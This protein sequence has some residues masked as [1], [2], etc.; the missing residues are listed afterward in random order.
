[1]QA[2]CRSSAGAVAL[3]AI[4]LIGAALGAA[5]AAD[6]PVK[7][8]AA[9][10]LPPWQ[11]TLDEDTRL[12]SWSGSRGFPAPGGAVVPRGSGAQ[13]YA[14][15]SLGVVGQ[16]A[17][18]HK[19]EF[20]IR[21]GVV[22][23]QQTTANQ[24]G[25]FS[26]LTD[27][28]ATGTYTYLGINGI[29]PYVSLALNLPTGRSALLGSDSNGRLDPDLVGIGVSGEGFNVGPTVG[30]NIPVGDSLM[31]GLAVGYTNRGSYKKDSLVNPATFTPFLGPT[32]TFDP[33]D[34]VTVT[35]TAAYVQGPL[36]WRT[37]ANGTF[38]SNTN[39]TGTLNGLPFNGAL[40]RAGDRYTVQSTAS[41]DWTKT[42]TSVLAAIYTH[43]NKNQVL[44]AN[45]PPLVTEMFNSNNDVIQ[46]TLDNKFQVAPDVV[47]GP[48]GGYMF[49]NH[50][51]W[52][53]TNALFVPEKTKWTAGGFFTY[54]V[55]K[56]LAL[57]GRVEHYWVNQNATPATLVPVVTD[58]GWLVSLGGTHTW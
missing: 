47:A 50:N 24:S 52:I 5:R 58:D 34:D 40:L 33:G 12:Y 38:E 6:M 36:A 57:N 16:T 35:G 19:W 9:A 29:Q 42:W 51:S 11:F 49:R 15:V 21:S 53:S 14:P 37:S 7:A 44:A 8:P 30:A 10:P 20:N 31:F 54:N 45:L 41:Y 22:W 39:V 4:G 26:A 3:V 28:G 48:T 18:E 56:D 55:F 1:M 25:A 13:L 2:I 32:S 27:T 17:P 23:S 43:S 46:L